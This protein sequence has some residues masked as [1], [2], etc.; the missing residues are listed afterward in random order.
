M[1][2]IITPAQPAENHSHQHQDYSQAA[3][4]AAIERLRTI[5]G[6]M[7]TAF[8]IPGTNQKA[9]LDSLIGLIPGVGDAITGLV[10]LEFIR[11]GYLLGA[12][13]RILLLMAF[14][15]LLDSLIGSVPVLGDLFDVAFKAN[16]KNLK[17]LEKEFNLE[18]VPN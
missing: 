16:V 14:N 7:D 15:I 13:K 12:R 10:S 9:G 17:L 3:R 5:A 2:E 4:A 11:Q 18:P 8:Q 6:W 1:N